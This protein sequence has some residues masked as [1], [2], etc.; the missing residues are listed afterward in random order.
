MGYW[1]M[2]GKILEHCIVILKHGRMTKI[3]PELVP[4]GTGIGRTSGSAYLRSKFSNCVFSTLFVVLSG[5]MFAPHIELT[6]T[7]VLYTAGIFASY[8]NAPDDSTRL[9][10]SQN[11]VFKPSDSK[12]NGFSTAPLWR[13]TT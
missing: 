11:H 2:F 1:R 6:C 10:S 5:L 7:S 13:Y 4:N 9:H 12:S 8:G 3:A